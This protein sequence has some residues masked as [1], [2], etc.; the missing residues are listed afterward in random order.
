MILIVTAKQKFEEHLSV[1]ASLKCFLPSMAKLFLFSKLLQQQSEKSLTTVS[2]LNKFQQKF[3]N[4][5]FYAYL[6]CSF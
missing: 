5:L 6:I 3:S 1:A 4:I 2:S